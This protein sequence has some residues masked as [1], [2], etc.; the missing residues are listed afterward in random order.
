M[1]F[2]YKLA[3]RSARNQSLAIPFDYAQVMENKAA[4][5]FA[6]AAIMG[7]ISAGCFVSGVCQKVF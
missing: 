1:V 6:L 2:V 7:I 3:R 5:F 4:A